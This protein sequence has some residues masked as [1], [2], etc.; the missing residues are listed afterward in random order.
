MTLPFPIGINRRITLKTKYILTYSL[1]FFCGSLLCSISGASAQ[2]CTPVVYAFRHAEDFGTNLTVVGRQHADLYTA[3]VNV[4]GAAHT[5]C[6]VGYVYS[7]YSTNPDGFGGTNN[8]YQTSQPLVT[9]ACYNSIL[10]DINSEDLAACF[11]ISPRTS[12]EN[13]G[14]LY[15]YLGAKSSEQGRPPAG[16][17][18]TGAE[19][20]AE[21]T[22]R[23]GRGLSSAIFWTSQ[24]L[25]VL[26][27]AIAGMAKVDIPGC[28]APPPDNKKCEAS[29]GIPPRNAAYVFEFNGSNAFNL[30]SPDNKYVQCFNVQIKTPCTP[31][32]DRSTPPTLDGPPTV[33][34]G[35]PS[36]W[37]GNGVD[38]TGNL[39]ATTDLTAKCEQKLSSTFNNL[40]ALVGRICDTAELKSAN[41]RYFG[42]CQ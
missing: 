25:N 19:L 7:M 36:Y 18:A 24:G 12:L 23:A 21:L 17:S 5:Y 28:S 33:N 2:S 15:E 34:S 40:N 3:M 27:Q 31:G 6:P 9:E 41:T 8:P 37:C 1:L 32:V 42:Y 26:G 39:P 11:S 35:S 29:K 4:F 20:R 38:G 16:V 10:P 22:G 13:G 30:T 14:K